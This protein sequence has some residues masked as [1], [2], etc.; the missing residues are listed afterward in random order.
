M[1]AP[2]ALP[3]P[4]AACYMHPPRCTS[5][6]LLVQ[7]LPRV[8]HPGAPLQV[9]EISKTASDDDIKKAYRKLALKLHP[10][11]VRVLPWDLSRGWCCVAVSVAVAGRC[12]EVVL[13]PPPLLLLLPLV[14]VVVALLLPTGGGPWLLLPLPPWPRCCCHRH[15]FC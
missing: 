11:K 7:V 9:L 2:G 10:D 6:H 13:R 3:V 15:C 12:A 14:V 5:H 1:V 4:P 8:A